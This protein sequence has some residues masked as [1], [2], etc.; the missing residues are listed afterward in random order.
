VNG[1]FRTVGRVQRGSCSLAQSF[2]GWSESPPA[3][4]G[5]TSSTETNKPRVPGDTSRTITTQF[6][7]SRAPRDRLV[8]GLAAAG[9][10]PER[11]HGPSASATR[12]T[13]HCDFARNLAKGMTPFR[14]DLCYG[15]RADPT[16]ASKDRLIVRVMSRVV[17]RSG[18]LPVQVHR[19]RLHNLTTPEFNR[20]TLT[21]P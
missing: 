16:K 11:P 19:T 13:L 10:V 4:L 2:S 1:N 3:S 21:K 15:G 9:P 5:T 12:R 17:W 20:C 14:A 8:A 7:R 18:V 6:I